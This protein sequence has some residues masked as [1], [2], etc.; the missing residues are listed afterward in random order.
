MTKGKHTPGP[1]RVRNDKFITT[2]DDLGPTIAELPPAHRWE[3]ER[4]IQLPEQREANAHLIVTAP[5]LLSVL[6]K[7]V[8]DWDGEPEDM[9]D[10]I[11]A[12]QRARGEGGGG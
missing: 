11:A 4:L 8:H 3:G 5:D 2:D 1:W 7:I 10:A 12:I 6:E 9:F